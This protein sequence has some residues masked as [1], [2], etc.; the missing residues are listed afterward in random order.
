MKL[1]GKRIIAQILFSIFLLILSSATIFYVF[2]LKDWQLLVSELVFDVPFAV[3]LVGITIIIGLVVG[4]A[5]GLGDLQKYRTIEEKLGEI[6]SEIS[7]LHAKNASKDIQPILEKIDQLNKKFKE[8]ALAAQKLVNEKVEVEE[9]HIQQIISEERNRLARELHDSVSQQLFAASMLMSAIN[10][11][12]GSG[13]DMSKQLKLV[14]EMIHQSQLEMRALLLHLRPVGLKGK[15]LREGIEQILFELKQKVPIE[16]TWKVE[17]IKLDRGIE[18]HLFRILQEA[19]SNTLR[20]AK[21]NKMDVLFIER[22]QFVILRMTDDGVGFN[23]N[24]ESKS[25]SYGLQNIRERAAEI[26]GTLK[27]VSLPGNGTR[28]EVKL[29]R[30]K[31][32]A[33]SEVQNLNKEHK[34]NGGDLV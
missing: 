31:K 12:I 27:I 32:E 30:W 22:D 6:P 23:V 11:S 4:L 20:H 18:D 16:I 24:E 13:G 25:G 9:K 8:Q 19:L 7:S 14:E 1:V 28:L 2:P 3:L 29:P 10:E 5:I 33:L 26:G 15:S 17:D 21:A 34:E